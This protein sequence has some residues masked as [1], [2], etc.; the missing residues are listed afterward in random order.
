M[1]RLAGSAGPDDGAAIPSEDSSM[2]IKY[3]EAKCILV[4]IVFFTFDRSCH[5]MDFLIL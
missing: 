2:R 4:A 3:M 1:N 5:R